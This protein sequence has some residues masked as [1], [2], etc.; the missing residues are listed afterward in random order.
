MT[1]LAKG[2]R[3][4]SITAPKVAN[5]VT[6]AMFEHVFAASIANDVTLELGALPAGCQIVGVEAFTD[7]AAATFDLGFLTGEYG[8][9]AT[10]TLDG[11]IIDDGARAT[12]LTVGAID[13]YATSVSDKIR[14]IG[15]LLS[16]NEAAGTKYIKV[17]VS[18]IAA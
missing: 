11:L 1:Q 4:N 7:A 10:R 6:I 14:G 5:M 13:A 18:Y 3:S 9:K 2:V 17:V 8:D 15:V 16:A 12:A